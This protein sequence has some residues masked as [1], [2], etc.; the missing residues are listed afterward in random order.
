MT[1]QF[2]PSY[3]SV[4]TVFGFLRITCNSSIFW[5]PQTFLGPHIFLN[6]FR[7]HFLKDVSIWSIIV[8]VFKRCSTVGLI[9]VVYVFGFVCFDMYLNLERAW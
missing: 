4:V 7:S 1:S 3:F 8:H 2:L 9:T 6:I 5:I